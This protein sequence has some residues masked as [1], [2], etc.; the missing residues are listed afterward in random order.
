MLREMRGRQER[1]KT[2]SGEEVASSPDKG[3]KRKR[4][5][6]RLYVMG[7]DL[8]DHFRTVICH[9]I[10]NYKL[11]GFAIML[12]DKHNILLLHRHLIPTF[13]L[14]RC[15][16]DDVGMPP[17]STVVRRQSIIFDIVPRSV[18]PCI[19]SYVFLS[20]LVGPTIISIALPPT[21]GPIDSVYSRI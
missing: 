18:Q 19:F 11:K 12:H 13:M 15:T 9:Q 4:E 1:G 20:S 17:C 21:Q 2:G 6:E 7:Y 16:Y 14:S 5:R 8:N 3:E 10:D